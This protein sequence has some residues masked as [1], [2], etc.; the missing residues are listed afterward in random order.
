LHAR[1]DQADFDFDGPEI[2]PFAFRPIVALASRNGGCD[3]SG[4][5]LAPSARPFSAEGQFTRF[6]PFSAV[7]PALAL[8]NAN[9]PRVRE[10]AKHRRARKHEIVSRDCAPAGTICA[11]QGSPKCP[12]RRGNFLALN[13]AGARETSCRFSHPPFWC[14]LT[15]FQNCDGQENG[16]R[17]FAA[18]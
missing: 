4:A 15:D 9:A 1:V 14:L 3:A 16:R 12:R 6:R 18:G 17:Q 2:A 11:F 10:R 7:F 5:I 8:A 13:R